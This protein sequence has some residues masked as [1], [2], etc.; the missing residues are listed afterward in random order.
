M[1]RPPPRSTLFP[2]TTLFRS[3]TKQLLAFARKEV[4]QPR[5]LDLNDLVAGMDEMLRR[6][7]GE[8]VEIVIRLD[9]SLG[10]V[11]ADAGQ[12]EQVIM[13]L[14]VNARDA[15]LKGGRLVIETINCEIDESGGHDDLLPGS[16]VMLSVSDTGL[17][18]SSETMSRIFEPFFTTKG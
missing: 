9:A 15:M 1:I 2:Y 3:L 14:V 12:V 5:V 10:R 7:I 8:D 18:M 17:G 13:N 16:Y 4:F 6:L 11:R